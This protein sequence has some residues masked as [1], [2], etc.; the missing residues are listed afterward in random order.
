[1]GGCAC[2]PLR[3]SG[4]L[5]MG[6]AALP[7][8]RRPCDARDM[9]THIR[10]VPSQLTCTQRHS[11]PVHAARA[12]R[13]V[14]WAGEGKLEGGAKSVC[15]GATP[16][17]SRPLLLVPSGPCAAR[18]PST[19]Q[20]SA[21]CKCHVKVCAAE[22]HARG[23]QDQVARGS[24]SPHLAVGAVLGRLRGHNGERRADWALQRP[25]PPLHHVRH[26]AHLRTAVIH[27]FMLALL[28]GCAEMRHPSASP[29]PGH[30][31]AP[32]LY[33]AMQQ[34]AMQAA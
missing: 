30:A 19:A 31:T 13:A 33:Q 26:P 34:R 22:S 10:G 32:R 2:C 18:L 3:C 6:A 8:A 27:L 21:A 23:Q 25:G 14:T 1:M 16:E 28:Q 5:G 12:E 9:R 20:P 11:C 24:R 4:K 7:L 15:M 17:E 29:V